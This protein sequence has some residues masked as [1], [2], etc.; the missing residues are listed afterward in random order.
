[1][2][3]TDDDIFAIDWRFVIIKIKKNEKR[4][5]FGN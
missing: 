4:K 3:L 1:M 5:K 2:S